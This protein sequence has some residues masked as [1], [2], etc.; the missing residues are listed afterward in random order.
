MQELLTT[1]QQPNI[2]PP[3]LTNPQILNHNIIPKPRVPPP[4]NKKTGHLNKIIIIN[5]TLIHNMLHRRFS[6]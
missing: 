5:D 1:I 4:T 6:V 3:T 2:R